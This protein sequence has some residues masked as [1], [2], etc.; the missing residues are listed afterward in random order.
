[1][2][3]GFR[4]TAETVTVALAALTDRITFVSWA[5]SVTKLSVFFNHETN[6]EFLCQ[7]SQ[8][9]DRLRKGQDL[10]II[11]VGTGNAHPLKGTGRRHTEGTYKARL[12]E[13]G[14][15]N[16]SQ[17]PEIKVKK[18]QTCLAHYGETTNLKCED[19]K[20]KLKD[21]NLLRY[22][23]ECSLHGGDPLQKK[24][25]TWEK[26]EGGNPLSDPAI[27]AKSKATQIK[28]GKIKLVNGKRMRENAAEL[29]VSYS[30]F[31]STV[32]NEGEEAALLLRTNTS[33]HEMML[34]SWFDPAEIVT[35]HQIPNTK[36]RP[37]I[38]FP[39]NKLIIEIDGLYWHSEEITKSRDYHASKQKA[40]AA[41]GYR[42]LFFRSDE[43]VSSPEIIKS[44]IAHRRGLTATR[45]F[46]RNCKIEELTPESKKTFFETNHLMGVGKGRVFALMQQGTPVAAIQVCWK[47]K[48]SKVLDVSRF[49]TAVNTS[50]SGGYS[51]LLA[52]ASKE[53]APNSIE[54]FCDLRYGQ[55]EY[56]SSMG[57]AHVG[58][59]LSFAWTNYL[60]TWHR[61][62]YPGNTGAEKGLHR[63]WDCGQAL[64]RRIL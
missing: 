58:T 39:S 35:N 1:M 62:Q 45:L 2:P 28:T 51:K 61:M 60:K 23:H 33:R 7:F 10:K 14:C 59:H 25:K 53:Y 29:G 11:G 38:L 27:Q 57:F 63:V 32:K 4:F 20:R 16:V 52:Y 8:L 36:F 44:M 5:G 6:T 19:T 3:S 50:V 12:L 13:T 41:Q 17:L 26:Y 22:G 40:Y 43:L 9:Q 49:C 48:D 42:S 24:L 64:Y 31:Q 37:D 21:T 46:A 55:P 54:T 30:A 56:L 15:T 18:K 47:R 34:R